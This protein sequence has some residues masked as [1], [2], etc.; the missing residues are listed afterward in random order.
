MYRAGVCIANRITVDDWRL[1]YFR[2]IIDQHN[3]SESQTI[4]LHHFDSITEGYQYSMSKD[5]AFESLLI[6]N[7]S[8]D[9]KV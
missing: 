7:Y 3:Y 1:L 8:S 5:R 9:N 2:K 6:E 4:N